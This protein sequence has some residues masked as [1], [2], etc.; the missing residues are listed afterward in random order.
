MAKT[1]NV[2]LYQSSHSHGFGQNGLLPTSSYPYQILPPLS[3]IL[4]S[5]G[6]IESHRWI[7]EAKLA[8]GQVFTIYR[9]GAQVMDFH[10][11]HQSSRKPVRNRMEGWGRKELDGRFGGFQWVEDLLKVLWKAAIWSSYPAAPPHFFKAHLR[12]WGPPCIDASNIYRPVMHQGYSGGYW[13]RH[14]SVTFH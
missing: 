4:G 3:R 11:P 2:I 10:A 13:V 14:F 12:L 9:D 1:L 5:H 7:S 6:L 8:N